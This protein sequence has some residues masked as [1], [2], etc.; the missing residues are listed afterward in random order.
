MQSSAPVQFGRRRL[1]F[2]GFAIAALAASLVMTSVAGAVPQT[3][4]Q[5][6]CVNEMNKR[7]FY[8]AR[9]QG[10]VASSCLSDAENG[11]PEKLGNPPQVQ[12]AQACLTNDVKGKVAKRL[13]TLAERDADRCLTTPEQLPGF[14][15]SGAATTGPAATA[16]AIGLVA[17]LFGPDLDAALVVEAQDKDGAR[18]QQDVLKYTNSVL[19]AVRKEALRHKQNVLEGDDRLTGTDPNAPV[20]NDLQLQAELEADIQ[21]DPSERIAKAVAKLEDKAESRCA[22]VQARLADLFPGKCSA[23]ASP[24]ALG[25]CAGSAAIGRAFAALAGFD[26]LAIDCDLTDNGVYDLSCESNALKA[27]VLNRLGYGPDAWSWARINQ[28]GVID[29]IEEQLDPASIDDSALDGMLAA[30]PSLTMSFADLRAN[31]PQNGNPGRTVVRRELQQA[32]LVRAVATHRQLA[33]VLFDVWMNHFNVD[34]TS[35]GRTQWDISP[36]DRITIRPNVLGAFGDLL[37]A[38][39]RSPAMGDYLDNRVNKVN[40]I[41][42]NYARELLELHTLSVSGPYH[43]TDVVEVARCLTGWRE[44]YTAA[45]GFKFQLNLH[46]QGTKSLFDGAVQIPANGGMQDGLTVLAYLAAQPST[47]SFIATKLVRRFVS[48]SPQPSLVAAAANTFSST[49][50]DI[51]A[52]LETILMSP[53]FLHSPANRGSKVKRPHHLMA[54]VA[55]ALGANPAQI[56]YAALRSTVS[57]LGEV[58]YE[59][60]PPPGLPDVSTFW[61]SPGTLVTRFNEVEKRARG[62]NGFHFTYPI[63]GGTADQIVDALIAELLPG[64]A[65]G[66][67]RATAIAFVQTLV[68]P[69]A[70]KI[71]QAA[72]LLMSSPEFLQH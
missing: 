31:Y 4:D 59:V 68:V 16:A 72:A 67:T 53:E 30:F 44:D 64:G 27:H 14:G 36:Y 33:E 26:E 66:D 13:T 21:A 2:A 25:A 34:A 57:V 51:R 37:L 49:G 54:S 18:C 41:N 40:G 45:D 15:Y 6:R 43:E 9:D 48:E 32:K 29:Y 20:A 60:P 47:A 55:R 12:T 19:D 5:Q 17:D 39:A 23:A 65:S 42:E 63:A 70:Q 28:L 10:K 56:N 69:D 35:S 61:A 62:L 1:R 50:G 52:T 22:I 58:L 11:H 71:E 3:S 7:G 38:D 24:T 8:V 46:D